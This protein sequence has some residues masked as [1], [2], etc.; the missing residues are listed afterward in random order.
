MCSKKEAFHSPGPFFSTN[1]P[2]ASLPDSS[3]SCSFRAFECCDHSPPERPCGKARR[4]PHLALGLLGFKFCLHRLPAARRWA[5][6]KTARGPTTGLLG[7][8]K[9]VLQAA[10]LRATWPETRL[11][12]QRSFQFPPSSPDHRSKTPKDL[13]TAPNVSGD[14]EYAGG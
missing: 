7:R 6:W 5:G 11:Q 2:N 8:A 4:G 1:E 14:K 12:R 9:G 3:G 13:R 10:A